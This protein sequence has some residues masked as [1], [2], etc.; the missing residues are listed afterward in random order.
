MTAVSLTP[1][2][3]GKDS[4]HALTA[5]EKPMSHWDGSSIDSSWASVF[6]AQAAAPMFATTIAL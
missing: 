2:A 1:E 4:I 5:N 6:A 3:K